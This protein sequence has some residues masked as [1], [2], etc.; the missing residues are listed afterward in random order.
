MKFLLI[1]PP[2][3][4]RLS[5]ASHIRRAIE[6]CGHQVEVFDFSKI[7]PILPGRLQIEEAW[8]MGEGLLIEKGLAIKPDIVLDIM[9]AS[10][11]TIKSLKDEGITTCFWFL[12][13]GFLPKY[14]Y[15]KDAALEFDFFFA[16]QPGRFL[17][18]VKTLGANAAYLPHGC[19]PEVHKRLLLSESEKR[20][21]EGNLSFMGAPYPN[22]V[23]AFKQ[24]KGYDFKIWGEGWSS[25]R[26]QGWD[27]KEG[28]RR[29]DETTAVKIFNASLVNLNLHS[30]ERNSGPP[31]DFANPRT[32][33]LAGCGAFQLVDK[34]EAIPSLFKLD[35]EIICF[36]TIEELKEK[37]GYYLAHPNKREEIAKAAQERAYKE[38]TYAHRIK[39][40]VEFIR[41]KNAHCHY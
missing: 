40:M 1:Y 25:F 9:P 39:Q 27:I 14:S 8:R 15:C 3:G 19:N 41:S 34:R 12:E 13:D 38:H 28:K 4:G 11:K 24:L 7:M 31:G 35:E 17:K 32:F 23:E 26:G 36:Q 2:S 21:Y 29:I 30:M 18:E 22:R 10:K 6:K 20:L 5:I 16:I 33:A 37:I